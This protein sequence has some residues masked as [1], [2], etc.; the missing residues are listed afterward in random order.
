MTAIHIHPEGIPERSCP[1]KIKDRMKS[2]TGTRL[3]IQMFR[4]LDRRCRLHGQH[5]WIEFICSFIWLVE[6]R[7]VEIK[8]ESGHGIRNLHIQLRLMNLNKLSLVL[9]PDH[10]RRIK[11]LSTKR[12]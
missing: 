3:Q 11:I 6:D 5:I 4:I 8:V 7:I 10:Y 9:S 12:V 1:H 2:I